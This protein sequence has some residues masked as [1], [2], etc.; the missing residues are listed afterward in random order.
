M[1]LFFYPLLKMR[2]K[3]SD[4]KFLNFAYTNKD[5]LHEASYLV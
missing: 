1:P 5:W 3:M 2:F 4:F